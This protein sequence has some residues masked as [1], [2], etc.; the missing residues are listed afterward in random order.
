MKTNRLIFCVLLMAGLLGACT[1]QVSATNPPAAATE[2]PSSALPTLTLAP[3]VEETAT[4][5]AASEEA[6]VLP[7][8]T[9]RGPELHATDPTTVSLA[10]GGLHFVEFFRFT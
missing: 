3:P 2:P 4:Q 9:S 5:P 8:A 10:S 7:V 1:P 6:A